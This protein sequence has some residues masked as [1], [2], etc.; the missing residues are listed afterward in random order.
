MFVITNHYENCQAKSIDN[1]NWIQCPSIYGETT[2]PL[3]FKIEDGQG[4]DIQAGQLKAS[5]TTAGID[6]DTLYKCE[7]ETKKGDNFLKYTA[8]VNKKG[9]LSSSFVDEHWV[10]DKGMHDLRYETSFLDR[11][12]G[13]QWLDKA[14]KRHDRSFYTKIFDRRTWKEYSS[15]FQFLPHLQEKNSILST[16]AAD[17]LGLLQA[18]LS[19]AAAK[20]IAGKESKL[21]P[22]NSP[23][24]KRD[25]SDVPPPPTPGPTPTPN[26]APASNSKAYLAI[27]A[28]VAAGAATTAWFFTRKSQE[29]KPILPTRVNRP[30]AITPNL[31][32]AHKM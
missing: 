5:C 28:V 23:K 19:V 2:D 32:Q 20:E 26:P 22:F 4:I 11:K 1:V 25:D 8:E 7:V 18:H 17:K 12:E 31:H 9:K 14:G 6:K 10:D 21:F 24:V 3:L 27:A 29:E 13:D 16:W 15:K 30:R